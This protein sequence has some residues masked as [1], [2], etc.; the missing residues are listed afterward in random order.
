MIWGKIFLFLHPHLVNLSFYNSWPVRFSTICTTESFRKW[1]QQGIKK[2]K[3]TSEKVFL[4]FYIPFLAQDSWVENYFVEEPPSSPQHIPGLFCIYSYW[5]YTNSIGV[6]K[7]S[8][9]IVFN[10]C[11]AMKK[12]QRKNCQTLD[13]YCF[14][15]LS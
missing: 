11:L 9:N 14:V 8:I 2:K 1:A 10:K 3:N 6:I 15:S 13:L 7:T 4:I 5:I 12:L